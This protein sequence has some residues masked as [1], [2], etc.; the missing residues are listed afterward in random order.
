MLSD[1]VGWQDS[2][3]YKKEKDAS[4]AVEQL[5]AWEKQ[6]IKIRTRALTTTLY[7]R[8][9]LSD[10]FLHGIGGA[11]Y[12]QVTDAICERFFGI[13]LPS[14]VTVSGT[15]RLPID[16]PS[17]APLHPQDL[18]Y[19]LREMKYHPENY[20]ESIQLE[21]RE[22]KEFEEIVDMKKTW[23]ETR[24]THTNAAERHHQITK[25]N[26]AMSEML[27]PLRLNLEQNLNISIEHM[28]VNKMLKSREYPFCLFPQ[29]QLR[30]F[31]L[32]F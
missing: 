21:N 9:L 30:S 4:Q 15:L 12:D 20:F 31:L 19:K 16:F 29:E 3:N 22:R 6:G 2:L 17:E 7:A 32:D 14:Y 1:R 5:A 18:R 23:V 24:K 28:R 8:L 10:L 25:A 27:N 26:D 13:Q 11:K